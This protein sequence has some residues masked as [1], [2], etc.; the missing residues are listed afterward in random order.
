M[1]EVRQDQEQLIFLVKHGLSIGA[2]D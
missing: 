1:K 2:T